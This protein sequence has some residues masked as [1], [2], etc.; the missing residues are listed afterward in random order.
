MDA[1]VKLLVFCLTLAFLMPF[2][3]SIFVPSNALDVD[4]EDLFDDYYTM[5]GQKA[6]TKTA[7][8]CLTGIYTPVQVGSPYGVTEDGWM[9]G[10]VISSYTPGQYMGTP[11]DYNVTR[12]SDNLYRYSADSTDYNAD[13]GTG[14]KQGDLY[15]MVNFD[16][17]H[18]SNI[19]FTENG[20]TM[21][22]DNFYFDYSGYRFS[23]QPISSYTTLDQNGDKVQIVAT[24]TSLSLV[25]YQWTT[26][27]GV[28]GQLIISHSDGGQ[29][30]INGAN[31]VSAFNSATNSATIPMVFA[32]GVEMDLVFR[33]DPYYLSTMTIQECYDNG[34]WSLMVTSESADAD[35]FTGADYALNPSKV[36]DTA[37]SL[38]TFDY[39]GYNLSQEMGILCSVFFSLFLYAGLLALCLEHEYLYILMGIM[40][41]LQSINL[42]HVFG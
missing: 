4:Q 12:G 36:L 35:A 42:F 2:M 39:S 6:P 17:D 13:K 7:I 10:S 19:F 9:Y 31:I 41:A 1:N 24:T 30:F 34:F 14:H 16:M 33:I 20:K 15:T 26:Q 23:F 28:S 5:T 8:W 3:F 32:N 38:F 22:G 27:T 11:E 21:M 40:T 25:F 37:I 18:K 29:G